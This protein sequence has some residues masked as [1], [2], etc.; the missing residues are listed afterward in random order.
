MKKVTVVLT[1]SGVYGYS[2]IA[3]M[4]FF[5]EHQ[6]RP[7]MIIGCSDGALIAALW[8]KGYSTEEALK[9]SSEAYKISLKTKLDLSIAFSLF[10]HTFR[11]YRKTNAILNPIEIN[12][13]HRMTFKEQLIEDLAIETVFQTTNIDTTSSHYIQKGVLAD[14]IYA[15]S[16]ILPFYPP[17]KIDNRWLTNGA[18]SEFLPLEFLLRSQSDVIIIMD[19]DI[20]DAPVDQSLMIYYAQFLQKALKKSSKPRNILMHELHSSEIIIIPVKLDKVRIHTLDERIEKLLKATR[21]AI[22]NKQELIFSSLSI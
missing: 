13:F 2:G 21:Q 20:P 4:E 11:K 6:I 15:S 1:G 22:S 19:P 18:F 14:A 5:H 16:A 12:H 3:L 8:A 9:V 17:I 7:N 10:K